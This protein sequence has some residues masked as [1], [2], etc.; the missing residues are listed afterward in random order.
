MA[1]ATVEVEE[2]EVDLESVHVIVNPMVEIK[3]T[4]S[5][6]MTPDHLSE[7]ARNRPGCIRAWLEQTTETAVS[8]GSGTPAKTRPSSW[9]RRAAAV[10]WDSKREKLQAKKRGEGGGEGENGD[11]ES[12]F[13]CLLA[14]FPPD[15]ASLSRTHP[16][17]TP[18]HPT[19]TTS[20]RLWVVYPAF[21]FFLLTL[22]RGA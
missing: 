14:Y 16:P 11:L 19:P 9:S 22:Y 7:W 21:L 6:S 17:H 15:F 18:T 12:Y 10:R 5:A 8:R 3:V 1:T 20:P 2:M 4:A 13:I